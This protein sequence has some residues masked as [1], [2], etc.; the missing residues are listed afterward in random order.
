MGDENLAEAAGNPA[1]NIIPLLLDATS[2][3]VPGA[4][5]KKQTFPQY[6]YF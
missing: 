3:G 5:N 1:L 4:F 6:L 2:P